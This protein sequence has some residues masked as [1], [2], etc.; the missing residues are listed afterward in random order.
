[1]VLEDVMYGWTEITS[2]PESELYLSDPFATDD[3]S[4]S[5]FELGAPG[6]AAI[7]TSYNLL[8]ADLATYEPVPPIDHP[9]HTGWFAFA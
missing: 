2:D 1:M 7:R 3:D 9:H 6:D 4:A 8:D 5:L